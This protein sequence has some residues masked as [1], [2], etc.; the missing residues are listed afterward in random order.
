MGSFVATYA[1]LLVVLALVLPVP[2]NRER[3]DGGPPPAPES[4]PRC[5]ILGYTRSGLETLLPLRARLEARLLFGGDTTIARGLV[6]RLITVGEAPYYRIGW[7]QTAG[8]DSVDL[9]AWHHAPRLRVPVAGGRGRGIWPRI[10]SLFVAAIEPDF[11]VHATRASC[12]AST[13]VAPA[14]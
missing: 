1:A 11:P 5:F 9:L 13:E 3:R 6:Y 7:W 8:P 14:V 12:D 10:P 4:E 2:V